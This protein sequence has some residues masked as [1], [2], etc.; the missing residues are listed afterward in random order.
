[1]SCVLISEPSADDII[2]WVFSMTNWVILN[3]NN[4]FAGTIGIRHVTDTVC[5]IGRFA[6]EKNAGVPVALPQT[7]I[8]HFA[9][10]ILK[11][12]RINFTIVSTNNRIRRFRTIM[13][14]INSG[15]TEIRMTSGGYNAE[16]ELWYYDYEKWDMKSDLSLCGYE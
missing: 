3:Q 2:M 16:L 7:L 13:G 1:M 5:T 10:D 4:E 11:L 12:Q 8:K 15:K 14:A 6:L 9:F